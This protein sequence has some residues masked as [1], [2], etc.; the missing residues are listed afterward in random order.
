TMIGIVGRPLWERT[1]HLHAP[2]LNAYSADEHPKH[3]RHS[4]VDRSKSDSKQEAKLSLR[5]PQRNVPA[6]SG[7]FA[8]IHR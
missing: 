1:I 2:K 5:S 6:N 4:T 8:K 3:R 7:K